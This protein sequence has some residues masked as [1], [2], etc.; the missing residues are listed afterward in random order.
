MNYLFNRSI[1]DSS[2]NVD[3]PNRKELAGLVLANNL[4]ELISKGS[5]SVK[6]LIY[7]YIDK[8]ILELKQNISHF[9][10]GKDEVNILDRKYL[11]MR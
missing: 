9:G 5:H 8:G 4:L 2:I 3:L 11:L 6:D 10:I 7:E 1:K